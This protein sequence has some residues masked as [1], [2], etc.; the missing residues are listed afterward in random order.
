MSTACRKEN[1]QL[2]KPKP[3]KELL[4]AG[5]AR[6]QSIRLSKD[7][8]YILNSNFTRIAGE[9]LVIEAGTL[10]KCSKTSSLNI[11]PGARIRAEGT[12]DN[13]IVFT[14]NVAAAGTQQP[15]DW[16]GI[17]I[18]GRSFN[19]TNTGTP[20][21][22]DTSAVMQYLRIEFAGITFK[23]CGAGT[24]LRYIQ[25]SY[26]NGRAAFLFDGG[27]ANSRYLLS[28]A[29][30]AS[31]DFYFTN[32]F[33]GKMQFIT[34]LRHPFFG[35]STSAPGFFSGVY[36]V[37]NNGNRLARPVTNPVISNLTVIGSG[38]HPEATGM[39]RDTVIHNA[40]LV[41]TGNALFKIRNSVFTGFPAAAWYM[42]D[43]LTAA[44]VQF[45]RSE[46]KYSVFHSGTERNFYLFPGSYHAATS[47]D[48]RNYMLEGRFKNRLVPA[49]EQLQLETPFN[50]NAINPFPMPGSV[51]LS[52]ADFSDAVFSDSWFQKTVYT[53]ALGN[54]NWLAGWV[55]FQPL[56]S[57]YNF[58][59]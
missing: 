59:K 26:A 49:L 22:N 25:V 48:F 13:P 14:S 57:D 17:V 24:L 53:G 15:G 18:E 54:E 5:A 12:P 23:S 8:V 45:E 11:F 33:S 4:N 46:V 55:N 35:N 32:G 44:S 1:V 7:T 38:N 21:P 52:G 2:N 39:Y 31:A 29:S 6:V 42:N 41:T 43:D 50:Y 58:F 34:A 9:E 37:N 28:Y 56:R 36:I 20:V 40:A 19:N 51:L 3:E 16:N 10:I 30:N 47:A 27:N